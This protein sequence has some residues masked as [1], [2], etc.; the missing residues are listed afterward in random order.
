VTA[1]ARPRSNLNYR[2]VLLSERELQ[3][4]KLS[5][6]NFKEEVKLVAGPRWVPD[7][8]TDWPTVSRNVTSTDNT[9]FKKSY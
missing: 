8:K 1:L 5:E 9:D 7:T 2:P 4:Y 3:N 6:E